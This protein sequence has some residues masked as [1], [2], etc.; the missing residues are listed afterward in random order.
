[1]KTKIFETEFNDKTFWQ[2]FDPKSAIEHFIPDY[3]WYEER[4]GVL[5]IEDTNNHDKYIRKI[6][7]WVEH[8]DPHTM[9]LFRLRG[10]Q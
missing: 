3:R 6:E 2:M 9:T 7:I 10:R 8:K 4:G 5:T 1:M